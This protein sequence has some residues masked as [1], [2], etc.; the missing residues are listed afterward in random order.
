[1]AGSTAAVGATGGAAVP[2]GPV[3]LELLHRQYAVQFAKET[4]DL[5]LKYVPP[6]Q[7][8][9]GTI[10]PRELDKEMKKALTKSLIKVLI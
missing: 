8:R 2:S 6:I 10:L 5:P 3:P 9:V 7:G 4:N 1:M